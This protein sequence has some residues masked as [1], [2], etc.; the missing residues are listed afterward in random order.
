MTTTPTQT[1]RNFS[2]YGPCIPQ[3]RLIRETAEFLIFA[4]ERTWDGQTTLTER[5][6]SKR[7]PDHYSPAHIEPC[8]SCEDHPQTQYPTGYMD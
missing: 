4:D 5:R 3:G 1:V 8:P 7:A 6:I 2:T